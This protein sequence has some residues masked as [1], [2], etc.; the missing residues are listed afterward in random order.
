[1]EFHEQYEQI[2]QDER[3]RVLATLI[4]LLGS[5]ELAEEATQE[6]FTAALA[7]W[8]NSGL[9]QNPRAWL[10]STGR[11]K[12]IDGL[13][14]SAVE[15]RHAGEA[16]IV[17]GWIAS[18][19]A[20]APEQIAAL[21]AAS[22]EETVTDDR[23]RLIFTC[24]HPALSEEAQVALTLRT[25]GGL[26]TEAIARA[27]LKPL[28]TIA[29]RLVRAQAKIRDARI[30][31]SVPRREQLGE[32][33]DAVLLVL[34]LIF[35]EGYG[36]APDQPERQALCAEAI[37]LA[38]LL[39]ELLPGESE[40]RGLLALM[41]LLHARRGARF[42]AEGDLVLLDQQDRSE[43]DSAAIEEGSQLAADAL[44]AGVGAYGLQAAIAAVHDHAR[45]ASETD[46][47]QIAAL[48]DVL[49]RVQPSPVVE[50]NRAVAVTMDRGAPA[51][52]EIVEAL[53]GLEGYLPYWAAKAQMLLWTGANEAAAKAYSR[54]VELARAAGE[55]SQERFLL[56][57][58]AEL[59]SSE[60]HSG[61]RLG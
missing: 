7:S 61:E 8:P 23:L 36:A 12:A 54:A 10:V 24:C 20:V 48:Y 17:S 38:R 46:W 30:P 56:K 15:Q 22:E 29:Q 13:R 47:T 37:R 44:R 32:R 40:V 53:Q 33:L 5:F 19:E 18:S 60:I 11:N 35:N 3:A 25:L 28:P 6:A 39:L 41:L 1:M 9:P 45:Q 50:L 2:W 16:A 52:L 55:A 58:L 31:Y 43:W 59:E 57:R 27:Y 21:D 51:G 49:L 4:R 26:T 42:T 14:R 34:Y